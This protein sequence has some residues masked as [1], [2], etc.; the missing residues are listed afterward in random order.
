MNFLLDVVFAGM[1]DALSALLSL[2]LQ[3]L[4]GITE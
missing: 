3:M 4:L 2:I 1:V